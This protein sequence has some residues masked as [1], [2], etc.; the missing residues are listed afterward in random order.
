MRIYFHVH[1]QNLV[2][3]F[4]IN[5]IED[6]RMNAPF[7]ARLYEMVL[8]D[9]EFEDNVA[10]TAASL[11]IAFR[12]WARAQSTILLRHR[13]IA[14]HA[15]AK[16]LADRLRDRAW[17]IFEGYWYCD[18]SDRVVSYND[19]MNGQQRIVAH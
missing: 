4:Q 19:Y 16:M 13:D 18:E 10:E 1:L 6:A 15:L 12:E 5:R 8:I 17:R 7:M 14:D 9:G 3:E 11:E 2:N